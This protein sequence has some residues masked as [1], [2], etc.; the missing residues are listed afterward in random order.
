MKLQILS[1]PLLSGFDR[2][3]LVDLLAVPVFW[4]GR[5]VRPVKR[6]GYGAVSTRPTTLAIRVSNSSRTPNWAASASCLPASTRMLLTVAAFASSKPSA[7]V[8]F[9]RVAF[10]SAETHDAPAPFGL[11]F[12]L[13]RTAAASASRTSRGGSRFFGG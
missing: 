4:M 10:C 5:I 3:L 1:V 13:A 6:T 9:S 11:R 7:F 2:G 12:Q 8:M